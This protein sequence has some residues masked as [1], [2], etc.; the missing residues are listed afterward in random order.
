MKI[1]KPDYLFFGKAITICP[2]LIIINEIFHD[3]LSVS[4][5][6]FNKTFALNQ[7]PQIIASSNFPNAGHTSA[8]ILLLIAV[9]KL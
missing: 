2:D 5:I 9:R 6:Y 8:S 7:A 1:G 3:L 4:I